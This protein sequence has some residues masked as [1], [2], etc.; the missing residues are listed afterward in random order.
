VT[1]LGL[2][3]RELRGRTADQQREDAASRVSAY[4]YG[5]VLV[6]AALIALGPEDLHGPTGIL[7]VLGTG[8]STFVAHV[9]GD[10]AG[11][12]IREGRSVRWSGVRRELRGS[13][14][15]ATAATAPAISL[16]LAWPGPADADVVLIVALAV[17]DLRLALLGSAVEWFSGE[18]SSLRLFLAGIGLA[19]ISAVAA[20]LKWQLTH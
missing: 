6:M 10:A 3:V 4:V 17:T 9:V 19:V 20:A 8:V 1:T 2:L 5:N 7:Y 15:I 12:R 11:R 18:R 16:L 14:P 13:M